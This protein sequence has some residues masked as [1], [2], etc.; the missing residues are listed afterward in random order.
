MRP[1]PITPEQAD[2]AYTLL[3]F[4][5]GAPDDLGERHAFVIHVSHPDLPCEEYR[6]CRSLGWGGKFR[7]NGNFGVPYVDCYPED[8]NEERLRIIATTN[9][10][11]RD[12][13]LP[14]PAPS[15]RNQI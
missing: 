12:L 6:C 2:A 14:T 4:H 11:L 3:V 9:K 8:L 15:S 5:A 7:N 10:A 13:F 1:F